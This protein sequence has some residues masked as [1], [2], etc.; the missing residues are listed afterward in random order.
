MTQIKVTLF[1]ALVGSTA[2][3]ST[4]HDKQEKAWCFEEAQLEHIQ[5]HM[6]KPMVV[7]VVAV[8]VLLYFSLRIVRWRARRARHAR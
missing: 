6:E 1:G 2:P 7:V 4:L 5:D 8:L 3:T